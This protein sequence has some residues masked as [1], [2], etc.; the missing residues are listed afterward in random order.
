MD[1][2]GYSIK[3]VCAARGISRAYVYIL[4]GDGRLKAVKDGKRTI[5]TRESFDQYFG[6]LPQAEFRSAR[7]T[8]AA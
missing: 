7:A 3:A 2:E 5:I 8:A 1:N 6:N 4:L